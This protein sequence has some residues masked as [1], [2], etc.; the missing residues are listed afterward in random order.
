MEMKRRGRLSLPDRAGPPLR[1]IGYLP[2]GAR[3]S[4]SSSPTSGGPAQIEQAY[5]RAGQ[6]LSARMPCVSGSQMPCVSGSQLRA[7]EVLD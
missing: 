7:L 2:E 3:S 4:R 5:W 1:Q 6:E